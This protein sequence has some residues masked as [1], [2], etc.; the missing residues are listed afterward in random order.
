MFKKFFDVWREYSNPKNILVYQFGKVGSTALEKSLPGSI[1]THM[2]YGN[3]PC[4]VHLA[5]RRQGIKKI[6]GFFGDFIKRLAISRRDEIKIVTIVREP[7]ARNVSMFFQDLSHWIYH[8]VGLG[9]HDNRF[10]GPEYL[11]DVFYK[12]FDH[13]YINRWFSDEFQRFTGIDLVSEAFDVD[14]GYK[15]IKNGKFNVLVIRYESFSKLSAAINEFIGVNIEMDESNIGD[16]KWYGPLYKEF[17]RSY[18]PS[19][20]YMNEMYSYPYVKNYYS[21]NEIKGFMKKYGN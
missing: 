20:E 19:S 6:Y 17:K 2:L 4:H 14:K 21:D 1:H 11:E 7:V 8:Y 10:T 12:S 9:N 13:S 3:S 18:A 15:V 16:D 5:Q